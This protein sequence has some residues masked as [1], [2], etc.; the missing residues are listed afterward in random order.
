[1]LA[2]LP[3]SRKVAQTTPTLPQGSSSSS[4]LSSSTLSSSFS[5]ILS[6][7][8]TPSTLFSTVPEPTGT[9]LPTSNTKPESR[10]TRT[11]IA[12]GVAVPIAVIAF[13]IFG[14]WVW[15]ISSRRDRSA[16]PE[17][18]P[19]NLPEEEQP[20]LQEIAELE[21]ESRRRHELVVQ[22]KRYEIDGN[23]IYEL[24]GRHSRQEAI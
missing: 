5:S 9:F 11:K 4:P 19:T 16:I 12:I 8:E 20:C 24:R 21:D 6:S 10:V 14:L 1:M 15:R 2:L 13:I 22:E 3:S 7:V 23:E 17:G 18:H